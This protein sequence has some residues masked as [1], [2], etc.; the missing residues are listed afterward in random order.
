MKQKQYLVA[1]LYV[2]I[3]LICIGSLSI[4]AQTLDRSVVA[5]A[6][7][8]LSGPSYSLQFT[9]GEPMTQT[10]VNGEELSQG[11]QQEWLVVT[12]V[13]DPEAESLEASVYPN[14]TF[15]L[16]NIECEDALQVSVFDAMG[17]SILSKNLASGKNEMDIAQLAT[18]FYVLVLQ[19]KEGKKVKTFK[20][21]K[22]E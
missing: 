7:Q 15:G 5:A 2:E 3:C 9:L 8:T 22:V 6:G 12:A 13:D 18:G 19:T 10:F 16:F 4:N 1:L 21:Q 11:F 14:P 17:K 20:L